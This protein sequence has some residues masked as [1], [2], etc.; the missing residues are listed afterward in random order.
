MDTYMYIYIYGFCCGLTM[1]FETTI[2]MIAERPTVC[3]YFSGI[4]L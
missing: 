3:H 2:E 1:G 4:S